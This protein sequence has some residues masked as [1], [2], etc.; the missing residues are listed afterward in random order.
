MCNDGDVL[1]AIGVVGDVYVGRVFWW[2]Q[3]GRVIFGES[4]KGFSWQAKLIMMMM[5]MTTTTTMMMMMMMMINGGDDDN[6]NN[7][8]NHNCVNDLTFVNGKGL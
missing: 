6:T 1:R 2:D 4:L 8:D 5:M 3:S 7:D